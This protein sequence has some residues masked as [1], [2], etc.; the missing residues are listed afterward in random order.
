MD[1]DYILYVAIILAIV[2]FSSGVRILNSTHREVIERF[3]RRNKLRRLIAWALLSVIGAIGK[4]HR[5]WIRMISPG[6]DLNS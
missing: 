3:G 6:G 2:F 5:A 1:F 4:I